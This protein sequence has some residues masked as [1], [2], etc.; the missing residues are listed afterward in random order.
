MKDIQ[1]K[2]EQIVF[3]VLVAIVSAYGYLIYL[4]YKQDT[5][6]KAVNSNCVGQETSV[7]GYCQ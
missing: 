7:A 1:L 4:G 2:G 3:V 5:G 6:V